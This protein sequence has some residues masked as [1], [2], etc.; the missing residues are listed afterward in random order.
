MTKELIAN[1]I[2]ELEEEI[3]S[4]KSKQT[5][6]KSGFE[7]FITNRWTGEELLRSHKLTDFGR[8]DVYGEDPNPDFNGVHEQPFLGTVEGTLQNAIE[9]AV[10]QRDWM[11]WGRGGTI[12]P[13]VTQII[14][15]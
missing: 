8:W 9:W 7:A 6:S 4:L 2:K 5:T 10:G 15:L 1:R 11:A 13:N 3:Q 12:K 14:I